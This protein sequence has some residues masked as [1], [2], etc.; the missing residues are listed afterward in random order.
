MCMHAWP[1]STNKCT[2]LG[3]GSY[4]A[5]WQRRQR[6]PQPR[7]DGWTPCCPSE[8]CVPYRFSLSCNPGFSKSVDSGFIYFFNARVLPFIVG[9][10]GTAASKDR[11]RG[12]SR[13]ENDFSN[14]IFRG[15]AT[16]ENGKLQHGFVPPDRNLNHNPS[17]LCQHGCILSMCKF[18]V[19]RNK[20]WWN[21]LWKCLYLYKNLNTQVYRCLG[22][23]T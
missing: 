11:S 8:K 17:A 5:I 1:V 12:G 2:Y 13:G 9:R 10:E 22:L 15:P 19:Q 20:L 18:C 23:L 21:W 3:Y 4:A 14:F 6:P 7:R 16:D